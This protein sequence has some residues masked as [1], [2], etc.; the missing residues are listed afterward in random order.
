MTRGRVRPAPL[1]I[2]A[3]PSVFG[4]TSWILKLVLARQAGYVSLFCAEETAA[5]VREA[6]ILSTL[7]G[8]G[9]RRSAVAA[10]LAHQE[11]QAFQDAVLAPFEIMPNEPVWVAASR[12]TAEA[13]Y[14]FVLT[15]NPKQGPPPD[16]N[17]QRIHES[18]VYAHPQVFLAE[19]GF[20]DHFTDKAEWPAL[21]GIKDGVSHL[22]DFPLL[23]DP[24]TIST[25]DFRKL[26]DQ[27]MGPTDLP[28]GNPSD[29]LDAGLLNP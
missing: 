7:A 11:V 13:L 23:A 24:D 3:T 4:E 16:E 5:S 9:H 26:L 22:G 12:L 29:G 27:L 8:Y 28:N 2:L 15:Q 21:Y 10:K 6:I 14:V 25:A 20:L 18:V 19:D 17:G 1:C